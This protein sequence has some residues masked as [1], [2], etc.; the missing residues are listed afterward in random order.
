MA[1]VTFKTTL[2]LPFL[3]LAHESSRTHVCQAKTCF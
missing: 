1:S 3:T 2:G